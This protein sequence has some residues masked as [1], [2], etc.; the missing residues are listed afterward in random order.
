MKSKILTSEGNI[1]EGTVLDFTDVE[2]YK[3]L[4]NILRASLTYDSTAKGIA[5][6]IISK[7]SLVQREEIIETHYD[8]PVAIAE[9]VT[10]KY[11]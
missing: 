7:Y 6:Q 8:G 4:L 5:V 3:D 11:G 1:I 10:I 2:T 9:P